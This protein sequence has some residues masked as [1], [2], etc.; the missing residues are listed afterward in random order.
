MT[1]A[2]P[3]SS[4]MKKEDAEDFLI[5]DTHSFSFSGGAQPNPSPSKNYTAWLKL[6]AI[7]VAVSTA[8]SVAALVISLNKVSTELV[9]TP[10]HT[11]SSTGMSV[12]AAASSVSTDATCGSNNGGHTCLNSGF[13]NC[14]SVN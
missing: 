6:I 7:A 4:D 10:S 2:F 1:K 9:S 3:H 13:G 12:L 8:I 11:N 14:C 5:A